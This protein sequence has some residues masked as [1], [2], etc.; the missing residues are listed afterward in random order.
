[1]L[2]IRKRLGRVSKPLLR[3]LGARLRA[4]R[5]QPG[6]SQERLALF[7]GMDRAYVGGNERPG[8]NI[9][10]L[11]LCRLCE[12]LQCD[13]AALPVGYRH[14]RIAGTILQWPIGTPL[15]FSLFVTGQEQATAFAYT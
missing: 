7:A 11:V 3:Q 2:P 13:V 4:R 1:M 6:L 9:T 5:K 15:S 12:T 14:F 10:F 8:R